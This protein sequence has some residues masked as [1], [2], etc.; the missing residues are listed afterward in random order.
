MVGTWEHKTCLFLHSIEQGL[1][2]PPFT[3]RKKFQEF[4]VDVLFPP[5]RPRLERR[6]TKGKVEELNPEERFREL[7]FGM[8]E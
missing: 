3:C 2:I 8:E 6:K 7:L 5:F 1:I 4:G